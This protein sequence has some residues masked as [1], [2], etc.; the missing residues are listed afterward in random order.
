MCLLFITVGVLSTTSRFGAYCDHTSVYPIIMQAIPVLFI[1]NAL[2]AMWLKHKHYY[3]E[4]DEKDT[5]LLH[6]ESEHS[7]RDLF[8]QRMNTYLCY[9][10][11]IAPIHL[12]TYIIGR[13]A[14]G[15]H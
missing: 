15:D 3:L 4:W 5:Y 1:I 14:V 6:A 10:Y 8:E 13:V 11:V 2:F 12:I 9:Q 7:T